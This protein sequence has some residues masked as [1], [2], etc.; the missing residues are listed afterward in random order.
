[1]VPTDDTAPPVS[2]MVSW[3]A[4]SRNLS[5]PHTRRC[6]TQW[7]RHNTLSLCS[8]R[9]GTGR[10]AEDV[11]PHSGSLLIVEAT[12]SKTLLTNTAGWRPI[13]CA[14]REAYQGCP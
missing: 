13:M 11:S 8:V 12:V 5:L 9:P 7:A 1:D 2:P 14:R 3:L 6:H 10:S 4:A